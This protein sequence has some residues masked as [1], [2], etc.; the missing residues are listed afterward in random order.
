MFCWEKVLNTRKILCVCACM[1]STRG[2]ISVKAAVVC[3]ITWCEMQ[4]KAS[5]VH[6]N[7][8]GNDNDGSVLIGHS[9]R[10]SDDARG[11]KNNQE[12]TWW[13]KLLISKL[14]SA[15]LF[16]TRNKVIVFQFAYHLKCL[17]C[18]HMCCYPIHY[19]G[20]LWVFFHTTSCSFNY[21]S[22]VE[23]I[24]RRPNQKYASTDG[25]SAL[26]LQS[27]SCDFSHWPSIPG[28][29]LARFLPM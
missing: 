17:H 16:S 9:T 2:L 12:V 20:V 11:L 15:N 25:D 8:K 14:N 10:L 7:G 4:V 13:I 19:T 18:F 23:S 27:R 21:S 22:G 5:A 26:G 6:E 28:N 3:K 1:N 24:R 29:A